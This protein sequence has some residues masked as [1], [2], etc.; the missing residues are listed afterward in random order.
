MSL[1]TKESLRTAIILG[2]EF[3]QRIDKKP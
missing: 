1:I 3:I 2:F